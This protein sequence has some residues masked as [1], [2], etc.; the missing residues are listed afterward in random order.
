M[1][2]KI[3]LVSILILTMN[4]QDYIA[5]ACQSALSQSYSNIEIIL[6]DN[7]SEDQTFE[8]ATKNLTQNKIPVQLYRNDQSFG[9]ARNLNFLLSKASGE[10]VGILSGDDWWEIEMITEKVKFVEK[11]GCDFALSDGYKFD[12]TSQKLSE[13]YDGNDKGKVIAQINDF[14]YHN[15]TENRTVNVGTFVKK[16][17]LD[18]HPFDENIQTEDWDMNLRLSFLGY[19]LGF[20][21]KK[22][23]YYR[24]L[25]SSLSRKWSVMAESYKKVTDKYMDYILAHPELLKKYQINL[26][27]FK[28]QIAISQAQNRAEVRKIENIWKAEKYRIKYSQPILFFKLLWLKLK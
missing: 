5:Q 10:Y 27:H 24:I 26:A 7:I 12:Q 2:D 23:F 28:Y 25:T 20:I 11:T 18:I 13:A 6:L 4:H 17:I 1:S 14:F 19:R 22:L 16:E 15:V 21:D 9:V 8:I 3:P